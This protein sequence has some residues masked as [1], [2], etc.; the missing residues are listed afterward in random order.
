MLTTSLVQL[1]RIRLDP[2][3]DAAGIY[4]YAPFHHDL[5]NMLVSQRISKVPSHAQK[6]QLA[7]VLASLERIGWRD[8]HEIP[9]LP[10]LFPKLRNGTG[11]RKHPAY[12]HF[13]RWVSLTQNSWNSQT[14]FY[15]ALPG[16]PES[17]NW[18][19]SWVL[20]P[21]VQFRNGIWTPLSSLYKL[22]VAGRS[23]GETWP[24]NRADGRLAKAIQ[25]PEKL[26]E[27]R[28]GFTHSSSSYT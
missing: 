16:D 5:G 22:F 20:P 21:V 15:F 4:R 6:N 9:S 7:R 18:L 12:T 3:P 27:R 1:W 25:D 28:L 23:I 13:A 11:F 2:T 19:V 24:H 17:R 10:N 26:C 8:R 14:D